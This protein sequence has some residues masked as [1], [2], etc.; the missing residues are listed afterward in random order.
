[1]VGHELQHPR[2]QL[3]GLQH[4]QQPGVAL[5]QQPLHDLGLGAEPVPGV[6]VTHALQQVGHHHQRQFARGQRQELT[7]QLLD[8]AAQLA[9]AA[10]ALLPL[11]PVPSARG[12][13]G[14]L[15][16]LQLVLRT[17]PRI[18]QARPLFRQRRQLRLEVAVLFLQRGGLGLLL[19][20][21]RL[22]GQP[23]LHHR[24][25][26]DE[27]FDDV[28]A[29]QGLDRR[30]QGLA[31]TRILGQRANLLAVEEEELRNLQRDQL[32]DQ[33]RPVCRERA[34][35]HIVLDDTEALA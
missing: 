16:L 28:Q 27:P 6:L 18:L 8:E 2:R 33:L 34:A 24:G 22:P 11:L 14:S 12:G 10:D 21:P 20:R 13:E 29:E 17:Q 15:R 19:R 30:P 9:Q 1:V 4:F 23:R 25:V 31:V 7:V 3:G 35:E 26:G 32:F 5:G